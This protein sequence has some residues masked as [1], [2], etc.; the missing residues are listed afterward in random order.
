M[1][2]SNTPHHDSNDAHSPSLLL[3]IGAVK[4]L[5]ALLLVALALGAHRLANSHDGVGTI[6][7]WAA[8]VRIDPDNRFIHT[9]I[10]RISFTD[11]KKL[12]LISMGTWVYAG[13]F[14]LEGVGLLLRRRWAEWLTCVIT[15]LFIPLELFEIFRHLRLTPVIVLIINVLIVIYLVHRLRARGRDLYTLT[16]MTTWQ[17]SRS[18]AGA[19]FHR[20]S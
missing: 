12:E 1:A 3:L 16:G 11:E 5:K 6:Y 10:S 18:R 4:I 9:L 2:T 19:L 14:T 15:G 8:H 17:R 13:L 7:S 20:A